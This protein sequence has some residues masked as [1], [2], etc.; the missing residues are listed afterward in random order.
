MNPKNKFVISIIILL[1][2]LFIVFSFHF[3]YAPKKYPPVANNEFSSH[4]EE[5]NLEKKIQQE[6]KKEMPRAEAIRVPILVY[7]SIRPY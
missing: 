7:N 4:L 3:P 2:L 5:L 1:G 6:T